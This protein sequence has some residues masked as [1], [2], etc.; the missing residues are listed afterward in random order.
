MIRDHELE[1]FRPPVRRYGLTIFL[2]LWTGWEWFGVG[3]TFWG[4]LTG[5]MAIYVY[6]R[7]ILTFPAEPPKED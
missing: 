6:Y 1:W 4:V 5:A 3:S 7:L 2:F